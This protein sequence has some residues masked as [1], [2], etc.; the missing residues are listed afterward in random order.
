MM[1]SQSSLEFLTTYSFLFIILGIVMSI[2]VFLS[3]APGTFLPSQCNAFSGPTCNFVALTSNSAAGYSLVTI[4]VTNSQSVPINI[5][6]MNT[7]IKSA[8]SPGACT[9]T[10]LYPGEEAT[11]VSPV[12]SIYGLTSLVEGYYTLNAQY[13][14]SGISSLSGG[15][16]IFE[17]VV[18]S[19]SFSIEPTTIT[20]V[21][22]SVVA[23]QGPMTLNLIPYS[24]NLITEPN[25]YTILQNGEW[26][27]NATKYAIGYAYANKATMIGQKYFTYNT[28]QFPQIF[29]SLSNNNI[30]CSYPYNSILS[31]ASTTLY[32]NSAV[33]LNVL[34]EDSGAIG[35]FYREVQP[36]DAWTSLYGASA[37]KPQSLVKY[38]PTSISLNKDFYNIEVVW[39]DSCG[40][41]GQAFEIGGTA[42]MCSPLVRICT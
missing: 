26:V 25:N 33:T 4:S 32:V 34:V 36:G 10:F 21:V 16:C 5:T 24:M 17:K 41:G 6:S 11:C 40:S 8:L 37:W 28:I 22:F 7:T 9:P 39:S 27:G 15:N 20:P 29:S 42:P 13:C 35:V 2:I 12:N 23:S 14:N 31:I 1:R 19:G 18:Y 3:M 38:G 30:A